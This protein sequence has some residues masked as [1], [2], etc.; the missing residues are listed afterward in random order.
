MD[1]ALTSPSPPVHFSRTA[2]AAHF[3]SLSER[4][5]RVRYFAYTLLAMVAC[6]LLLILIYLLAL[7]LP[8]TVG[9]L[10]ATSSFIIVKNV[11]IPMVVFVMSIRR[12]HDLD[13]SG[14]WAIGVLIPFATLILLVWPARNEPNR[15][16]PPPPATPR[17]L[18]VTAVLLPAAILS[19][20]LYM[21]E[22]NAGFERPG[23]PPPEA[24]TS[25]KS[26]PSVL[27]RYQ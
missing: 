6:G 9:K 22:I 4:V 18:N 27:P 3:F 5:G 19:L 11:V 25:E 21:V 17:A 23:T 2:A 14:W 24:A 1:S 26:P 7:L 8:A 12:L 13:L 20:Y 16:G 15:Y 10:V